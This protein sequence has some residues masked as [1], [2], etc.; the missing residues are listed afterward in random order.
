MAEEPAHML[1]ECEVVLKRHCVHSADRRTLPGENVLKPTRGPRSA[2]WPQFFRSELFSAAQSAFALRCALLVLS[3]Q[4]LNFSQMTRAEKTILEC[5]F[6]E[7]GSRSCALRPQDWKHQTNSSEMAECKE[8]N[9]STEAAF[10]P[11]FLSP[12]CLSV[13]HC[14][15]KVTDSHR[16]ISFEHCKWGFGVWCFLSSAENWPGIHHRTPKRHLF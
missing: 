2:Q 10:L 7:V 16:P 15:N 13:T 5:E 14:V 12:A 11:V 8:G 3:L 4:Q 6:L 1:V 9:S